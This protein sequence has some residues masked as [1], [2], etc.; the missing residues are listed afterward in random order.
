MK[1][2]LEK[3][4]SYLSEKREQIREQYE[5]LVRQGKIITIEQ[6]ISPSSVLKD[7]ITHTLNQYQPISEKQIKHKKARFLNWN[8]MK[9][10]GEI[11]D[12]ELDKDGFIL[13]YY[14]RAVAPHVSTYDLLGIIS[15]LDYLLSTKFALFAQLA[16]KKLI[17]ADESRY[18]LSDWN[19]HQYR[20]P[21]LTSPVDDEY[22][23]QLK[24]KY[25]IEHTK[26]YGVMYCDNI[27]W[28]KDERNVEGKILEK[29]RQIDQNHQNY[30]T[31]RERVNRWIDEPELAD[32]MTR[33]IIAAQS[34]V[35]GELREIP[36]ELLH[37]TI[38]GKKEHNRYELKTPGNK[39]PNYGVAVFH[40]SSLY[41]VP[42]INLFAHLSSNNQT[43]YHHIMNDGNVKVG[44]F[45][46]TEDLD[47]NSLF[48]H[49]FKKTGGK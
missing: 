5:K 41:V 24:S 38:T 34:L 32:I 28:L 29:F 31:I 45:T 40:N 30:N 15:V 43:V 49:I 23:K 20:Y 14:S 10:S 7:I 1:E 22:I 26:E 33:Y 48:E 44:V 9:D 37:I 16:G 19:K 35:L 36:K 11:K 6:D 2:I 39:N 17:I 3:Y 8:K 46:F 18:I 21:I 4:Q 25:N 42:L 27:K 13:F 12:E 47:T